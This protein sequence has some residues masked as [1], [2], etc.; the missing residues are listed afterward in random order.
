MDHSA[1]ELDSIEVAL[2]D[3]LKRAAAAGAWTAVE[4][5]AA[6]LEA[7]RKERQTVSGVADAMTMDSARH[8]STKLK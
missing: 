1:S 8:P 7:R 2:A 6:E 4:R 5:L 3:A